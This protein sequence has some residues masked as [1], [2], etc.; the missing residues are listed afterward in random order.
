MYMTFQ[1]SKN[2]ASWIAGGQPRK[3]GSLDYNKQDYTNYNSDI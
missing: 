2:V 1:V 3:I